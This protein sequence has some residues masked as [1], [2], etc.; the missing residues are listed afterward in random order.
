MDVE[1][2][3]IL[4]IFEEAEC[5]P[6]M[7]GELREILDATGRGYEIVCVDDGSQ[8][9]T[10]RVLARAA[11][12]DPRLRVVTF[13]RNFGKEAALH[14]GLER[15]RGEAALV[16]DADGQHPPSLIPAMLEL[17]D[18]GHEVVVARKR[19]RGR[20]GALYRLGAAMFHRL[21]GPGAG[22]D[23]VGAS[24]FVLLGGPA[25]EALRALPERSRFFR[26]LVHWIGFRT[27]EVEFD[28]APR[29]GG[30]TGWGRLALARYALNG[31]VSYTTAPLVAIAAIGVAS[32]AI[33][34]VL[35]A[36]ALF[37]W[38]TGRAV[39]GFTT[40]IL[41]GMISSGLILTGLGAQS[42]YLSRL[43]DEVK[44]RPLYLVRPET[45][46]EDRA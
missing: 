14:A 8:D 18:D 22:A 37:D 25:L 27:A 44:A 34:G 6:S 21:V 20:E 23:L 39:S 24:D 10:D 45:K 33:G 32:T 30:R 35:G 7:L 26:G 13:S 2:S 9:G 42:L 17:W 31:I 12:A 16:L 28:V 19:R 43:F 38:L 40:V 15:A 1:L 29:R 46:P 5:L 3:V 41:M 4:P 36:I 11:A